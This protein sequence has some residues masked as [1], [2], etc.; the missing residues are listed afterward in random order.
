MYSECITSWE[1]VCCRAVS[2][3]VAHTVEANR[4]HRRACREMSGS[5]RLEAV[6]ICPQGVARPCANSDHPEPRSFHQSMGPGVRLINQCNEAGQSQRSE[7]MGKHR[8]E[9]LGSVAFTPGPL[10][11]GD[12]RLDLAS[13]GRP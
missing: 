12:H 10:V 11:Q 4:R 5:T 9:C 13:E 7:R 1:R 3:Q 6:F 8:I 2:D